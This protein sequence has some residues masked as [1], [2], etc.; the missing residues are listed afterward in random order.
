LN[1]VDPTIFGKTVA[2][3]GG[4]PDRVAKTLLELIQ[5]D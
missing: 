2:E 5:I 4:W 1:P 3:A